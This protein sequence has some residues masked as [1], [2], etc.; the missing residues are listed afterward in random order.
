M[1]NTDQRQLITI[2]RVG[3]HKELTK[4]T[5]KDQVM[6]ANR[7]KINQALMP[8]I[9]HNLELIFG[10][11]PQKKQLLDAAL[12]ISPR[13][14]VQVDRLAKRSRDCLICW[15][16]ENWS[17]VSSVLIESI[18]TSE[19]ESPTQSVIPNNPVKANEN[20]F[21]S[22]DEDWF[23]FFDSPLEQQRFPSLMDFSDLSQS[24][25]MV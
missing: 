19:S 22:H 23:S 13:I 20:M 5:Q 15:F 2:P 25:C 10:A 17:K 12:R 3:K 24:M 16:C 1:L 11:P 21:D 14:N 8:Q 7:V 18:E 4:Q 9:L 6:T